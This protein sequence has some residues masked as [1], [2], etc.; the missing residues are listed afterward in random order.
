VSKFYNLVLT[1]C[2]AG[3]F[4]PVTRGAI[5]TASAV[6]IVTSAS[7]DSAKQAQ[8]ALDWLRKNG[9][10]DLLNRACVVVNHVT[11]EET[12]VESKDLVRQ[13]EQQ[14]QPGRVVVL[15]W[16][17]HIAAGT[18]IQLGVLDPTYKRRVL[19]LAAALSDDFEGAGRR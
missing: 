9:H 17:K 1:D 14:V 3:F 18:E 10:Q 16:D 2:G 4:D 19:E 5:S 15:P 13:F 8:V 6:V 7:V 12:N 11:P